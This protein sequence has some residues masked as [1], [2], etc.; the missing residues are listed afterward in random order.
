M[1]TIKKQQP[2][3]KQPK[4]PKAIPD[5]DELVCINPIKYVPSPHKETV[6]FFENE[7]AKLNP[8]KPDPL[9]KS[10]EVKASGAVVYNY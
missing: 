8:Y 1:T 9:A 7:T 10:I 3:P 2:Q 5:D 6:V 4:L